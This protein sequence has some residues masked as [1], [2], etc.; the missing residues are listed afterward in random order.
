MAAVRTIANQVG[1]L[2]PGHVYVAEQGVRRYHRFPQTAPDIKHAE[3][4]RRGTLRRL[5]RSVRDSRRGYDSAGTLLSGV[6]A[7]SL[8][9]AFSQRIRS[10]HPTFAVGL[11]NSPDIRYARYVANCL[12]THH[13]ERIFT[14]DEAIEAL[15]E[16]ISRL[17]SYHVA[18]V[19]N[20]IPN[21]FATKLA[22]EHVSV[23]LS[24]EGAGVLF[25]GRRLKQYEGEVLHQELLRTTQA[26]HRTQLLRCNSMAMAHDLEVRVPFLDDLDL[27]RF[28]LRIAPELKLNGKTDQWILRKIAL[29]LLPKEVVLRKGASFASGSGLGS[30]LAPLANYVISDTEFAREKEIAE[31]VSLRSKEELM[32]YRVF[33]REFP[34]AATAAPT[35]TND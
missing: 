22:S 27:V 8:I 9:A 1:E 3:T 25:A 21:Y 26:L 4:A 30:Q 16:V 28:A 15:P 23:A 6:L 33:S 14:V 7:S 2:P 11:N 5:I 31:G 20:A 12:G 34:D 17:G 29:S 32:Y 13:H 18:L 24:G 10:A 19:R 35:N